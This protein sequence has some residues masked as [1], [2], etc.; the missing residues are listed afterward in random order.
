MIDLDNIN[1][2]GTSLAS[3][4]SERMTGRH[5]YILYLG[6]SCQWRIDLVKCVVS[7]V[8]GRTKKES[9]AGDRA[10]ET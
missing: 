6:L 3:V 9:L 8:E 7:L 4:L 2:M 1:W 10:S 5:F